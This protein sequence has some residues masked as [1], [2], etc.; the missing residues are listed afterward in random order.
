MLVEQGRLIPAI[1]YLNAQ[2]VRTVLARDFSK[3]WKHLDCL[4][5]PATPM[6]APK[7]GEMTVAFGSVTEDVRTR[8]HSADAAVQRAG[9]AGAGA[10]VRVFERGLADRSAIGGSAAA[11][12]HAAAGRRSVWKTPSESRAGVRPLT[13]SR[14]VVAGGS[15][16]QKVST[17]ARQIHADSH[18]GRGVC[19]LRAGQRGRH[20]RGEMRGDDTRPTSRASGRRRSPRILRRSR[21]DAA[22]RCAACSSPGR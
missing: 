2:R 13:L 14:G 4:M 16:S 9:L 18:G 22:D 7:I 10:A 5:T 3:I 1:D 20:D 21:A 12:R 6:T 11:G 15:V 8:G 19:Q 17:S